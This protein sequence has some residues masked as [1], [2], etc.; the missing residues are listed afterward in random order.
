MKKICLIIADGFGISPSSQKKQLISPETPYINRLAC[1][2]SFCT[3]F[4]H[5]K[6][7]GL[8]DSQAG[9]SEVGHFTIGAGRC[10]EQNL[11]RINK[12]IQTGELGEKV[13]ALSSAFTKQVHI[14]G[15]MSDGGIHSHISHIHYLCDVLKDGF[16]V[17]VHGISDGIDTPRGSFAAFFRTFESVASISGRY[18]AMDRDNNAERTSQVVDML[19]R[20]V[21]E[22]IRV[23]EG[24]DEYIKPTLLRDA[25]IKP[26]E[27]IIFANIRADR[28]RQLVKKFYGFSKIYTLTDYG[29]DC[30][31]PIVPKVMVP[32]MLPEWL[33]I[34]GCTQTHIGESEKYA[35]VTYFLNG[36][37]EEKYRNEKRLFIKSPKVTRFDEKPG[38]SMGKVVET[39]ISEMPS[40]ADIIIANLAGPDL[41]GHTGNA[42]RVRESLR[43]LDELIMKLHEAC[44]SHDYLLVLTADHGNSEEMLVDGF[45]SKSHTR[46]QVPFIITDE[47]YSLQTGKSLSSVAPTVLELM[48][49]PPPAEMEESLILKK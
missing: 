37:N 13:R 48:G 22:E 44:K 17:A 40:E 15:M 8:P 2:Y 34:N 24:G 33:E 9:N 21:P 35:H 41:V 12:L 6:H 3:L 16:D 18:Y 27:T 38:V 46:N 31:T 36:E 43:I 23:Q 32:N 5:G 26:G 14:I 7:V 39:C 4:A 42:E 20:G 45:V 28:M 25:N 11:I 30:A 10:L 49:I 47:V 1:S 19:V 29:L